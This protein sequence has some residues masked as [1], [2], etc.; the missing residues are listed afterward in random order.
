MMLLRIHNY[1]MEWKFAMMR[2]SS[3]CE[4]ELN[5]KERSQLM[6]IEVYLRFPCHRVHKFSSVDNRN[7]D[8]WPCEKIR[9]I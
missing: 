4:D 2:N 6:S 3:T 8:Y 5:E 7:Q 9:A 1:D